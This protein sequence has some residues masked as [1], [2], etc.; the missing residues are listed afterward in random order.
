MENS[1][2]PVVASPQ[3]FPKSAFPQLLQTL[4]A[5]GYKVMG[6]TVQNGSIQWTNIQQVED[7]PIGWRDEQTPGHYRLHKTDSQNI[8][9][10]VHGPESLK[11]QT[12][13]PREP[14]LQIEKTKKGFSVQESIP[15]S[16]QLA[17]LGIRACD[18]AGLTIQDR[19]FLQ[20]QFPDPY[21]QARRQNLFLVAVNC[22]RAHATCFCASMGTG[23]KAESGYDLVLTESDQEFLIRFGKDQVVSGF[24]G[25]KKFWNPCLYP[26]Q[27]IYKLRKMRRESPT[28]LR[29]KRGKSTNP[30]FPRAYMTPMTTRD[31]MRLPLAACLAPI[32][33]WYV[34]PAFVMR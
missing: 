11:R 33:R 32:A 12:F 5:K 1:S 17:I 16:E 19:I 10:I 31:G 30:A 9:D 2:P 27:R 4:K 13:A 24:R 15:Q 26:Q 34:Q 28:V 25:A 29:P 6:P 22:T 3:R 18:L 7:L 14:L 8:F 21:Y 20:D 23:P